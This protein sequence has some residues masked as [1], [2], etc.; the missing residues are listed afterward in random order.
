MRGRLPFLLLSMLLLCIVGCANSTSIPIVP[1]AVPVAPIS[2]VQVTYPNGGEEWTLYIGRPVDFETTG[3]VERVNIDLENWRDPTAGGPL[4]WRLET[5]LPVSSSG[6]YAV[7]ALKDLVPK[8]R[9]GDRFRIHVS[10]ADSSVEDR[11]DS[12][13]SIIERPKLTVTSPVAREDLVRENPYLIK[14]NLPDAEGL[15]VKI[16][17]Q[18]WVFGHT[19]PPNVSTIAKSIPAE[20][21]QYLWTPAANVKEEF[22]YLGGYEEGMK[23]IPGKNFR[24]EISL[25]KTDIYGLS[26]AYFRIL[27]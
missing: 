11:S 2:S 10:D 24:V 12:Y 22:I 20:S 26:E 13:F 23:L 3:N 6:H 16:E 21:G 15:F 17:L 7:T 8:V 4:T 9:P 25:F 5:N 19:A 18:Q 27:P 14:W 1:S